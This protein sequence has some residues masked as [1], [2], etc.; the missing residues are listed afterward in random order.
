MLC[1]RWI[2]SLFFSLLGVKSLIL[3]FLC[4]K[5]EITLSKK[6]SYY[7]HLVWIEEGIKKI[8]CFRITCNFKSSL[9]GHQFKDLVLS[10]QW[11]GPLLW[12]WFSSWLGNGHMAWKKTKKN[13]KREREREKYT[14]D[15][16]LRQCYSPWSPTLLNMLE[17]N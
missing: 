2:C 16:R 3:C 1:Q 9:L 7:L 13:K 8:C 12:C 4:L 15:F 6:R 5:P 17:Y 10:L 11:L 14:C